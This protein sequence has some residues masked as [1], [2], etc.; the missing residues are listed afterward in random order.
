VLKAVVVSQ[1][2]SWPRPSFKEI[3]AAALSLILVLIRI[4]VIWT[5]LDE[6]GS[7]PVGV[8]VG[9]A[10]LVVDGYARSKELLGIVYPLL[11]ATVTFWLGVAIEGRR[12]D[13]QGEAAAKAGEQR[14]EA[15]LREQAASARER[16]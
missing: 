8:K 2:P 6:I 10:T 9:D 12:A 7:Q 16:A 3:G 13:T 14:D 4:P 5:A 15:T 11:T 1:A